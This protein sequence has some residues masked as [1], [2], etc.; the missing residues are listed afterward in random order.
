MDKLENLKK[1]DGELKELSHFETTQEAIDLLKELE[2]RLT[3]L[4]SKATKSADSYEQ[5]IDAVH[6]V[7]DDILIRNQDDFK[8]IP[9]AEYCEKY[10]LPTPSLPEEFATGN[11]VVDTVKSLIIDYSYGKDTVSKILAKQE[12]IDQLLS[13]MDYS[14]ELTKEAENLYSYNISNR[15]NNLKLL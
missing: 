1:L 10:N 14:N 4:K 3:D 13:T 5:I 11:E 6:L 12:E 15:I 2:K 9:L 7:R 8:I